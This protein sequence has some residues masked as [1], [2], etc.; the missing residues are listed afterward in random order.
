M[1]EGYPARG[2]TCPSVK[3]RM[4]TH[5][6]AREDFDRRNAI[7]N[8]LNPNAYAKYEN[9]F[10]LDL[11]AG[12]TQV[13]VS[14]PFF[15]STERHPLLLALEAFSGGEELTFYAWSVVRRRALEQ[16]DSLTMPA[17]ATN[18]T[19][20]REGMYLLSRAVRQWVASVEEE[21]VVKEIT[22]RV[23]EARRQITLDTE[24]PPA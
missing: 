20:K 22:V 15:R 3:N 1:A 17:S 23:H 18:G 7:H 6:E 19:G 11:P 24:A 9:A 13:R 2:R 21:C 12:E 5:S 8:I 10:V 14:A 4:T 16:T